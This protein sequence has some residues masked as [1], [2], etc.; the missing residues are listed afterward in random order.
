MI[1]SL[2]SNEYNPVTQ[3]ASD[4]GVGAFALEMNSGFLLAGVGV[5]SLSVA[6]LASDRPRAQR[7]GGALLLPAGLALATDAFFQTDLEGAAR[8]LHG[9]IH[10][11]GGFVFFVASPVGLLLVNRG[12]GRIRFGLTLAAFV[13]GAA[14]LA[15]DGSLGLNAAGL[16][17]RVMIL[18]VFA[19]LI[20]TAARVYA[21]A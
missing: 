20:L 2:A 11:L 7:T 6:V 1:L 3:V 8:T 13:L 16:A 14:F 21:E 4:Y 5:V 17:E 10:G 19:S 18:F 15:L 12:F 9:T